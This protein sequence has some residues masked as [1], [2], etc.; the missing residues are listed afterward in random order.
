LK[1]GVNKR[2]ENYGGSL[3]NRSRLLLEV[4]DAVVA[5]YGNQRVGVKYSPFSSYN[6][7]SDSDTIGLAEHITR[8]LNKKKIAFLDIQEVF[9]FD[10][11]NNE[12]RDRFFADKKHKNVRAYL[13]PLF[14]NGLLVVNGGYDFDSAN[15]TI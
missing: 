8:E 9:T 11:T 7:V 15:K 5:V 12:K 1:N 3:E 6:D 13:K 14:T 10:A 2:T 4:V